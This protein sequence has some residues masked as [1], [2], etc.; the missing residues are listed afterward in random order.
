MPFNSTMNTPFLQHPTPL[1]PYDYDWFQEDLQHLPAPPMKYRPNDTEVI[2]EIVRGQELVGGSKIGKWFKNRG[3][4]VKKVA[5]QVDNST[6]GIQSDVKKVAYKADR[7]TRGM[8]AEVVKGANQVDHSVKDKNGLGRHIIQ[9]ANDVLIPEI[10]SAV[11]RSIAI[12][13]GDPTGNSGAYAGKLGGQI[14]RKTL[15]KET[16]YGAKPHAGASGAKPRHTKEGL[17]LEDI[18]NRY[19][20]EY[21]KDVKH[22]DLDLAPKKRKVSARNILI[23]K[24]MAENPGFTLPQA[25]KYIKDNGLY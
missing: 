3:N 13:M 7:D 19:V 25:S 14:A 5:H 16:G 9:S 15:A 2:S 6:K 20:P 17:E 22:V 12:A 21:T 23:K 4:D 1:K 8:Q 11:G 10:A 24:I 18:I